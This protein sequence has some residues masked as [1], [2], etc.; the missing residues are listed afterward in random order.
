MNTKL[1]GWKNLWKGRFDEVCEE[2]ESCVASARTSLFID[3]EPEENYVSVETDLEKAKVAAT[4]NLTEMLDWS[5]DGWSIDKVTDEAAKKEWSNQQALMTGKCTTEVANLRKVL[6]SFRKHVACLEKESGK[7]VKRQKVAISENM[8]SEGNISMCMQYMHQH[9]LVSKG[10]HRLNA[11]EGAL[12][13]FGLLSPVVKTEVS[14][15][16]NYGVGLG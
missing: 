10:K 12:Q 5:V 2:I 7:L 1:S 14:N 8:T 16:C 9:E 6:R 3:S 11:T 15:D 4:T 13:N